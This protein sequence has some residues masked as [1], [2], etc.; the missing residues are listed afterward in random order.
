MNLDKV[1]LFECKIQDFKNMNYD[2]SVTSLI[3]DRLTWR[4]F[5]FNVLCVL[6]N[7]YKGLNFFCDVSIPISILI[8]ISFKR[9]KTWRPCSWCSCS[10]CSCSWCSCSWRSC[11]RSSCSRSSC[12][13]SS[14][15]WSFCSWSFCSC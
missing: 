12:S 11:S 1:V 2:F 6:M 7:R 14:C 5:R 3:C 10:W 15:S 13:R 4:D 9:F 8:F